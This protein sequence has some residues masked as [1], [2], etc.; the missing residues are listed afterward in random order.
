MS[1]SCEACFDGA[2]LLAD[3]A[4]DNEQ[5]G[6]DRIGDA[7]RA[8]RAGYGEECTGRTTTRTEAA[9]KAAGGFDTGGGLTSIVFFQFIVES[10]AACDIQTILVITAVY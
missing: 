4:A 1:E 8:A 10:D 6:G 3:A 5:L 9:T 2:G 7:A